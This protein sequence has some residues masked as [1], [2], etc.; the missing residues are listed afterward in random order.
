MESPIH[1]ILAS[2]FFLIFTFVLIT[3]FPEH[4]GECL[5]STQLQGLTLINRTGF[6]LLDI[7]GVSN[8]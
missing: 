7:E 2:E 1:I 3:Y 4:D 6:L 5:L 8:F